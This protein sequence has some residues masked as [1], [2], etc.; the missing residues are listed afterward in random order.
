[1]AENPSPKIPEGQASVFG[2]LSQS[3]SFHSSPED[4]IASRIQVV[5]QAHRAGPAVIRAKIL[6]RDVAIISSHRLCEGV[7]RDG[8]PDDPVITTQGRIPHRNTFTAGSAYRQL[9]ADFFPPPNLLLMDYDDHSVKR[10]SWEKHLSSFHSDVTPTIHDITNDH[11]SSWTNSSPIDLHLSPASANRRIVPNYSIASGN[12]TTRPV[13]TTPDSPSNSVLA[14]PA[15]KRSRSTPE[16]PGPTQGPHRH[17]EHRMSV[18]KARR[19]LKRRVSHAQS[20]F[21]QFTFRQGAGIA[22]HRNHFKL[23]H[24]ARQPPSRIPAGWDAWLYFSGAARDRTV[25]PEPDTFIPERYLEPDMTKP[26]FAFGHGAKTCLGK[27]LVQQ[28][29]MTVAQAILQS[30]IHLD[31]N[32]H[33]AGV[34]GWLGWESGVSA[35]AFARDLKQLPC[36][37]PKDPIHIHVRTRYRL[38]KFLIPRSSHI[39]FVMPI[40]PV[41][42]W[43]DR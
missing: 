17:T 19:Y 4:F 40:A 24:Y 38:P 26:G 36:Q 14:L 6:N 20:S 3:L 9:M 21:Y 43:H 7:L 33:A 25:Y 27:P 32:V 1:M 34:R 8:N 12:A 39:V 35:D 42:N 11:I 37:R 30:N 41:P 23:V 16:A 2:G 13:L 28:I 31:G 29:V 15:C 10:E 22:S 5:D 18:F